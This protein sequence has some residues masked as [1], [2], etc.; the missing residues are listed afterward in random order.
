VNYLVDTNVICEPQQKRPA[1]SVLRWL[2]ENES[3]LYTS[4]LVTGEIRYGIEMLP[5][6]NV[7]RSDLFK[8]YEKL[9]KI[10]GG[11]VLSLNA[12]VTEEW[13][14]LQAEARSK[15]LVLPVVD[16]LLAATAR[17][18]QL[19][20]ATANVKDFRSVGVRVFNPFE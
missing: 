5:A 20:I 16:S 9:L 13:A 4:V 6:N 3:A 10:M 15:N 17:R 8:W 14:R 19:V 12:R 1:P 11:R 7:R 2:N 18:Y